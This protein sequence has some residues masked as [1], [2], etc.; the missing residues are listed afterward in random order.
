[1]PPTRYIFN[2]IPK[3]GGTSLL[4]ICRHNLASSEI[5]P[6][7]WDDQIRV[8]PAGRFERFRLIA[9]HFSLPSHAKLSAD[10]YSMT[11]LRDPIRT[12]LSTYTFWRGAPEMNLATL[13][14]K[15]RSFADFVR[16]FER[17]PMVISNPYTHHFAGIGREFADDNIDGPALLAMAMHNLSAFD[18]IG[19]CEE[20]E[21]SAGL[22]CRELGWRFPTVP[23]ENRSGSEKELANID[24]QTMRILC[25]ANQLDFQLYAYAITLFQRHEDASPSSAGYQ[26]KPV[27]AFYGTSNGLN[28]ETRHRLKPGSFLPFPVPSERNRQAIVETVS[29]ALLPGGPPQLLEITV[30]FRTKINLPDLIVGVAIFD[31]EGNNAWGTN[32]FIQGLEVQNKPDCS[33][34]AVFTLQCDAP[35]GPYSVTVA[36]QQPRRLGFHEHWLDRAASFDVATQFGE[37]FADRFNLRQ[38]RSTVDQV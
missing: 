7:L 4:A 6:H 21:R 11:L 13:T 1:M 14:A 16:Y 27:D 26:P 2:H 5:S 23:H 31:G 15:N 22:L 36:L 30:R 28:E 37:A 38:F 10:R 9:G 8:S 3:T 33:C 17:S 24:R 12:I 32:T 34:Y 35:P 18:F 25:E 29:A 19:I 20:Y